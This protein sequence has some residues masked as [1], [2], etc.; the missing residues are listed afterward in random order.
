MCELLVSP[1]SRSLQGFS[2]GKSLGACQK[3]DELLVCSIISTVA[4]F[5]SEA[6]GAEHTST[7]G[8][9]VAKA[10]SSV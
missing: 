6:A 8:S 3:A 5:G 10:Q 4:G 7:K 9:W 2:A 1:V